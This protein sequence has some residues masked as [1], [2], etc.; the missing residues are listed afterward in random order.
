[1]C[2]QHSYRG[3]QRHECLYECM[4]TVHTHERAATRMQT[5]N[6]NDTK[7]DCSLL[8]CYCW[9]CCCFCYCYRCA[10]ANTIHTYFSRYRQCF[11]FFSSLVH[12]LWCIRTSDN[13]CI[14]FKCSFLFSSNDYQF[15]LHWIAMHTYGLFIFLCVHIQSAKRRYSRHHRRYWCWHVASM[16]ERKETHWFKQ[17]EIQ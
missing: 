2:T 6:V 5:V 11:H 15:H 16:W 13:F 10:A 9:W 3:N 14:V 7:D 12:T 4:Y 17:K 8:L 1:M